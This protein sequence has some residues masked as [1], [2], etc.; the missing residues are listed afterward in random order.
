M[1]TKNETIC[2]IGEMT[3]GLAIMARAEG[4]AALAFMLE[5]AALEATSNGAATVPPPVQEHPSGSQRS[6]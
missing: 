5:M 3:K 2:Y 4:F 1:S 6:H